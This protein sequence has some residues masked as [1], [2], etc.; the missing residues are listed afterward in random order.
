M[1]STPIPPTAPATPPGEEGLLT[2]RGMDSA[3]LVF[4]T[5]AAVHEHQA[6]L[7]RQRLLVLADRAKGRLAVSLDNVSDMTSAGVNALVAVHNRCRELGGTLAVFGLS[8]DIRRMLRV[9]RLDRTIVISETAHEAVKAISA[10]RKT[11][12]WAALS[13]ARSEKDAA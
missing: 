9:T 7:I 6:E 2:V 3:A 8:R 1:E 13:W 5:A 12:L 4:I 11:G 10:P